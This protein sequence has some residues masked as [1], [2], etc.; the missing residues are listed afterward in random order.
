MEGV[1][2][3][4]GTVTAV[5]SLSWQ[6]PAGAVVGLIGPNG[7]GKSTTM[8]L[9]ID[10][11]R[12]T[13]GSIR[14]LGENP[15]FGGPALRRRLGY[16]PGEL[17]AAGTATGRQVLEFFC[18][19]NAPAAIGQ[20]DAWCERLGVDPHRR[21]RT[22]SK[23]NKQKLGVIQAFIHEPELLILDEPTSGLDPLLQ[24]EFLTITREAAETGATVLLSSHVLGEIEHIAEHAAVLNRGRLVREASVADLRRDAGHD[25]SALLREP[26]RELLARESERLLGAEVAAGLSTRELAAGIVEVTGQVP[27]SVEADRVVALLSAFDVVDF[28]FR[29]RDLEDTVL[30]LYREQ[31]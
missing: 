22:L 5:D 25:F 19:L 17:T 31:P 30:D 18:R 27:G 10:Y 6:V 20:I 26:D 13:T 15:R 4:F 2:K 28:T 14:V 3:R 9:L 29:Q 8:R 23:G 16:L 11:L 12:P 1:T 21:I 7:A 24:Y